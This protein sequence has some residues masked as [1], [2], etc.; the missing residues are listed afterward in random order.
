MDF[1]LFR[2]IREEWPLVKT[3]PWSFGAI[4]IAALAI[5]FG[6][7]TLWWSGTVSTLRERLSFAQDKL[8][9]ALSGPAN[10]STLLTKSEEGR[11]LS[12]AEKQC[13]TS[14]FKNL[15]NDFVGIIITSFSNDEAQKYSAD[16]L[17][18]FLRMGFQSG[19]FIGQPK[20]YED[21]GLIIG[22]KDPAHPS[23][24]AKKFKELLGS[25]VAL[26]ERPLVWESPPVLLPKF[27]VVDFNL[28][29]GPAR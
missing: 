21:T 18:L 3:A 13:I 20:T 2:A 4:A 15:N 28:F 7:A 6:I 1:G 16:F 25:C 27:T 23:A 12:E 10:P 24:S 19:I 9:V 5:G 17:G 14:K 26:N 22:L 11:R 29:V 8:Q